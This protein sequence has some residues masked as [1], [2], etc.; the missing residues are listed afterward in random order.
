METCGYFAYL[1]LVFLRVDEKHELHR[2]FEC[3][4]HNWDITKI[5]PGLLA[6]KLQPDPRMIRQAAN[7]NIQQRAFRWFT[8]LGKP[9]A[10]K[11]SHN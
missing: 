10:C 3:S 7:T 6:G 5:F 8:S 2:Q 11:F 4:I 9:N 1:V